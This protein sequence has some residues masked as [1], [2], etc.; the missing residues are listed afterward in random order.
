[1]CW[2]DTVSTIS[3]AS[4]SRPARGGW[5]SQTAA[6][7]TASRSG[8]VT[9]HPGKTATILLLIHQQFHFSPGYFF[10]HYF[11]DHTGI[12]FMQYMTQMRLQ[13][14]SEDLLSSDRTITQISLAR[15]FADER[16]FFNAFKKGYCALWRSGSPAG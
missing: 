1:M 6:A 7:Y 14:A 8:T 5:Q 12:T 9:P 4:A 15:G 16:G 2:W 13:K 3:T 11:K 10:S